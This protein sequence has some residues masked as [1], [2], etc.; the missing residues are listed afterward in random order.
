MAT[1][2]LER[3]VVMRAELAATMANEIAAEGD[4]HAWLALLS[5]VETAIRA[6]KAVMG[7]TPERVPELSKAVGG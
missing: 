1:E 6:V 3:L 5:Q 2:L 4:W 7:E